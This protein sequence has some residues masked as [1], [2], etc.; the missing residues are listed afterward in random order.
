MSWEG[1]GE[2]RGMSESKNWTAKGSLR[3][4]THNQQRF[5]V[6]W[7]VN[8]DKSQMCLWS[9]KLFDFHHRMK[10]QSVAITPQIRKQVGLINV[11]N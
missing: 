2:S 5:L 3:S 8:E 6:I 7:G 11:V 9:M 10:E 1:R 4:K